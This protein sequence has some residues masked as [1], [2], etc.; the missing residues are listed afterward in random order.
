M[1]RKLCIIGVIIVLITNLLLINNLLYENC[2][3]Y[4]RYPKLNCSK[5]Y[6][7]IIY[8][9]E[10]YYRDLSYNKDVNSLAKW[11]LD[12][13]HFS[14]CVGHIKGMGHNAWEEVYISD[15]NDFILRSLYGM[16]IKEGYNFPD[17]KTSEIKLIIVKSCKS[18]SLNKY[19]EKDF[20]LSSAITQKYIK[21]I[22]ISDSEKTYSESQINNISNACEYDV[23]CNIYFNGDYSFYLKSEIFVDEKNEEAYI[24]LTDKCYKLT[25]EQYLNIRHKIE[26]R[27][28]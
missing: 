18:N 17:E 13:K 9:G 4:C 3:F 27:F 8:N 20:D 22:I 6:K 5:D 1:K 14:N 15:Y 7:K 21:D 10:N 12:I 26:E 25:Q 23:K 24:I 16:W 11:K 28:I 2:F 19:L